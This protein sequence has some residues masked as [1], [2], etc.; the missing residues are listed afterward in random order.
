MMS[1]DFSTLNDKELEELVRD[2]LNAKY[3]LD[4]QSFRKGPDGGTDLRYSTPLNNNSIVIQVKHYLDSPYSA[5]K[6]NLKNEEYSK[7]LILK[8]D[9]YIVATS[10]GLSPKNKDEIKKIFQPFIKSTN[11]ILGKD[12][13]NK[14]LIKYPEIEIR[15]FKLW[16]RSIG[17]FQK[18]INSSVFTRTDYLLNK[19]KEKTQLYVLPDLADGVIDRIKNQ[20]ILILS[21]EPGI[22]KTTLAEIIIGKLTRENVIIYHVINLKEVETLFVNDDTKQLFFIDDF[23]GDIYLDLLFIQQ[24]I[25]SNLFLFDLITNLSIYKNK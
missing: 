15:Y 14:L 25:T 23:L 12:D 5:L 13:L 20:H 2:L 22:G 6:S 16:F 18:I 7:V 21:G 24:N 3:K 17:N 10:L 1:Y 19:I 9:R 4:L 11:D 8:P